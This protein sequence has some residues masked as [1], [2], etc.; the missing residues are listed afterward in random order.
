MSITGAAPKP[1]REGEVNLPGVE[2]GSREK[3]LVRILVRKTN[4]NARTRMS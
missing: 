1:R 3:L 2:G 4:K